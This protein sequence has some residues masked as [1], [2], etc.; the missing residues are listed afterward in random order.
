MCTVFQFYLKQILYTLEICFLKYCTHECTHEHF[1]VAFS[2]VFVC[3]RMNTNPYSPSEPFLQNFIRMIFSLRLRSKRESAGKRE[4]GSGK[5]DEETIKHTHRVPCTNRFDLFLCSSGYSDK[6]SERLQVE[7]KDLIP[8]R[9]CRAAVMT[10]TEDI[11]ALEGLFHTTIGRR[12]QLESVLGI[13]TIC[14]SLGYPLSVFNTN[15]TLPRD[16]HRKCVGCRAYHGGWMPSEY[17]RRVRCCHTRTCSRIH[18]TLSRPT[19]GHR[20]LLTSSPFAV[21]CSV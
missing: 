9:T 1:H 10:L 14:F 19:R 7:I 2:W 4:G 5:R 11:I 8:S 17:F 20:S 21:T 3:Q 15:F 18:Q 6:I 12:K 13:P 16:L